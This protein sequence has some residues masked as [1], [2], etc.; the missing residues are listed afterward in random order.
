[1]PSES[2]HDDRLS[3]FPESEA[4][5]IAKLAHS[6]L[7]DR[8][9]NFCE[10]ER[11]ETEDQRKIMGMNRPA[12][13]DPA[14]ASIN[15]ALPWHSVAEE[16]ADL[17]FNIITGKLN[18]RMKSCNPSRSWGPKDFFSGFTRLSYS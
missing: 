7:L 6:E 10:L 17:N 1:M 9:A 12:Y 18:K 2:L 13:H 3:D 5:L 4:S 15:L 11:G 14:R 8:V 16:I